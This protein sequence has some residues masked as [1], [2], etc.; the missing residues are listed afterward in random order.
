MKDYQI[1]IKSHISTADY[2]DSCEAKSK[3]EAAEIF[4]ERIGRQ[5]EDWAV[6][7]LLPHIEEIR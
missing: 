5:G 7:D 3:E 4:Q 1:F 2:E 6:E